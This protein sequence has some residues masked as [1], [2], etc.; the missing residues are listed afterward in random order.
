MNLN[1]NS[2]WNDQKF[3]N[4]RGEN[5]KRQS[6]KGSLHLKLFLQQ[7]PS[8]YQFVFKQSKESNQFVGSKQQFFYQ[9]EFVQ[10]ILLGQDESSKLQFRFQHRCE[11]H[12]DR[13]S[14]F[15]RL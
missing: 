11:G 10:N 1:K 4:F 9:L 6:S 13:F 8:Q 2:N 15:P 14:S 5:L 7:E 3:K 12:R